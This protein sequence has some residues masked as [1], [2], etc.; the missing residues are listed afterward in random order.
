MYERARET[1]R[2]ERETAS[3]IEATLNER[4]AEG[5]DAGTWFAGAEQDERMRG[6]A[7]H[8]TRTELEIERGRGAEGPG[9]GPD[10]GF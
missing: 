6:F 10:L 4:R 5:R 2:G 7:F 1:A 8:V 3:E 9:S